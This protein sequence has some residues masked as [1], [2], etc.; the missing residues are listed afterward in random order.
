MFCDNESV[1]LPVQDCPTSAEL[2]MFKHE[3]LKDVVKCL[4]TNPLLWA[5]AFKTT[6]MSSCSSKMS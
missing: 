5:S 2:S 3:G 4:G 1:M 6:N